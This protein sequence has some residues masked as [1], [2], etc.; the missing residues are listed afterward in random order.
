ML[1]GEEDLIIIEDHLVKKKKL[2]FTAPAM[3]TSRGWE[4]ESKIIITFQKL[5][6]LSTDWTII[7]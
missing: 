5:F 4:K 1:F 6:F 2:K 7:N 3:Q